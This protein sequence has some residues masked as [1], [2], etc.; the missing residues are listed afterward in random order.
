MLAS[1]K[2]LYVNQNCLGYLPNS[3]AA[4]P[5]LETVEAQHNQLNDFVP[6]QRPFFKALHYLD[7]STN[8]FHQI[9]ASILKIPKLRTLMLSFNKLNDI[10]ILWS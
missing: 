4:L 5:A 7:L 2:A 1:L 3:L 9:P 6:F 8:R 10:E